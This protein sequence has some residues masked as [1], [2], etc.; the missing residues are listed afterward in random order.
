MQLLLFIHDKE[1]IIATP[2]GIF[3]EVTIG[4]IVGNLGKQVDWEYSQQADNEQ[5]EFFHKKF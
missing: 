1:G 2:S 5:D 3:N 4:K